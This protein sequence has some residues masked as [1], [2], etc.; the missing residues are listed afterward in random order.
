MTEKHKLHNVR[1]D[2]EVWAAIKQ[3][4][5]SLNQ[6]LRQALLEDGEILAKPGFV[7]EVRPFNVTLNNKQSDF[8]PRD[9]PGVSVGQPPKKEVTG[10]FPC[11]CVHSGCRGSKFTG[12]TR[13]Q[14]LCPECQEKDHTGD[15]RNCQEC[16]NDQG[17]P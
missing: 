8:D 9:I 11:R 3:M 16:F 1:L 14:N 6:Y 5:C 7:Q 12:V 17:A 13:F 2:D 15:P 10:G 4:D